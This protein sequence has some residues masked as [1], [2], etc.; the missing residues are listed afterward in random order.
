MAMAFCTSCGQPLRDGAAFCAACGAGQQAGA[1]TQPDQAAPFSTVATQT[2]A[3]PAPMV[4]VPPAPPYAANQ[5]VGY[6][7]AAMAPQP[8]MMQPPGGM[9]MAGSALVLAAAQGQLMSWN[10]RP[11][12]PNF[13]NRKVVA[14]IMGIFFGQLG[15]HKFIIGNVGAGVAMLAITIVSAVLTV[16][17]IGF[18]GL[19]AMGIIGLIE[20]IIYLT[21]SDEEFIVRYG[22]NHKSWF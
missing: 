13:A 20:G 1:A 5:V 21:K 9:P 18:L 22:I 11:L 17:L 6:Q 2:A 10:G 15:I 16:V 4:A 8:G 19:A 3:G 7:T 12:P 14:G